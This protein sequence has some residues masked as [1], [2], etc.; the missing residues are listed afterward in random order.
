MIYV[1]PVST[2]LVIGIRL[3]NLISS[4]MLICKCKDKEL[5][6]RCQKKNQCQVY[7]LMFLQKIYKMLVNNRPK[8][9]SSRSARRYK[10]IYRELRPL[11]KILS[12]LSSDCQSSI[13]GKSVSF[14]ND[15]TLLTLCKCICYILYLY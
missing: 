13:T 9:C 6:Y 1:L 14:Q 11:S 8:K 5:W 4:D 10:S 7:S 15:F 12:C 3:S 2:F